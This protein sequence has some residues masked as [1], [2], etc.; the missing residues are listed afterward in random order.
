MSEIRIET[1]V[2]GRVWEVVKVVGD[3]VEPAETV[4]LVESMKM[5]IPVEAPA[6][7]TVRRVDVA[8][9]EEI[10]EGQVVVVIAPA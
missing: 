7:G 10:T 1:P 3:S 8:V 2:T 5:E 9:G 6:A 4:L